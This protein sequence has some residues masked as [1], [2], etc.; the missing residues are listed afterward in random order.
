MATV[1]NPAF[2]APAEYMAQKNSHLK[3]TYSFSRST[4]CVAAI[5]LDTKTNPKKR[6]S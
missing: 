2:T 5:E 6:K 1:H 4:S 3:I